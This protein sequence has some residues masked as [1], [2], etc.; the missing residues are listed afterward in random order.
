MRLWAA[1]NSRFTFFLLTLIIF[2][3]TS[4]TTF[5]FKDSFGGTKENSTLRIKE[6]TGSPRLV[7]EKDE[8]TCTITKNGVVQIIPESSVEIE[9]NSSEDLDLKV[10]CESASG[11][12]NVKTDINIETDTD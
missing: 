4:T 5:F 11:S 8:G 10:V 9:E 1:G 12:S 3:I 7:D 2:L 6:A